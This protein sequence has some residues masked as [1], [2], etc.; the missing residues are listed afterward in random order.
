MLES[1]SDDPVSFWRHVARSSLEC[2]QIF[3]KEIGIVL[4]CGFANQ[5]ASERLNKYM[6]DSAG[7]KKRTGLDLE[8]MRAVL[9]LKVHL[10]YK[11]AR[12]KAE[13][14]EQRKGMRSIAVDLRFVYLQSRARAQEEKEVKQRLRELRHELHGA[15]ED[16]DGEETLLTEQDAADVL[17][18]TSESELP[19]AVPNG[20]TICAQ[21]PSEEALTFS[22]PVSDA[23][24]AL[25]GRRMMMR[26]EGFGWLIGT[27][28]SVNEDKRR[29]L[30]VSRSE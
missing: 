5:S 11:K 8:K 20:F 13:A 4:V 18:E 22:K 1:K 28:M 17:G 16:G 26:W 12:M 29:L 10:M 9:D 2:D 21:A 19:L 25:C 7:D 14:A 23:S 15:E 30:V 6:A 24:K 27:I 3:A